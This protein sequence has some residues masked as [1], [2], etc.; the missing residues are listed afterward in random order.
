M[1][2]STK[3]VVRGKCSCCGADRTEDNKLFVLDIKDTD[4]STRTWVP[5]LEESDADFAVCLRCWS[6]IGSYLSNHVRVMKYV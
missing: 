1:F 5:K 4:M 6:F 3:K 2:S